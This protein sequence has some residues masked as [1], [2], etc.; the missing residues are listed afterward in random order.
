MLSFL[1]SLGN[2]TT[3]QT[4]SRNFSGDN[5]HENFSVILYASDDAH[6][7]RENEYNIII[8]SENFRNNDQRSAI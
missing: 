6:E 3:V 4:G 2:D 1:N 8:P 7:S 5:D